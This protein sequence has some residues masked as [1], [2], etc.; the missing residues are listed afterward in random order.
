MK[1]EILDQIEVL[2][3]IEH[4]GNTWIMFLMT[5][6]IYH[7]EWILFSKVILEVFINSIMNAISKL[8][9]KVPNIYRYDAY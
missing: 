1:F 9:F 3:L 2:N 4:N 8:H 7:M 6:K 5:Q